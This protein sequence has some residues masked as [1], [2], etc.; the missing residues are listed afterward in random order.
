MCLCKCSY[1]AVLGQPHTVLST[2]FSLAVYLC[3]P[4]VLN[5]FCWSGII[6]KMAHEISSN[7]VA[8]EMF[9]IMA[10]QWR[11]NR[12]DG[13]LNHQP[14]HCLLNRLFR[15]RSKKTSKLRVTGFCVFTPHKWPATRKMFPFD[16]VIMQK[17]KSRSNINQAISYM[18]HKYSRNE[19]VQ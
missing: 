8:H 5:A 16:D 4:T 12:R 10:L 7:R 11:N 3:L 2:Q 6:L 18:V 9:I 1:L 15:R 19:Q 17:F 13:V 14:H